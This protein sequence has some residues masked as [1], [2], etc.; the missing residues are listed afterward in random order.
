MYKGLEKFTWKLRKNK[1]NKYKVEHSLYVSV[2]D[3]N[4]Y[5]VVNKKFL[6][7][8]SKNKEKE[9]FR[10]WVSFPKKTFEQDFFAIQKP[11]YVVDQ[12]SPNLLDYQ[13]Q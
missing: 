7:F 8:R 5:L 13:N 9:E 11:G 10:L 2:V 4:F 12:W 1:Q 6:I 3:G